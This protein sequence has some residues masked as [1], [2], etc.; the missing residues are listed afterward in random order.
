MQEKI[1][2]VVPI[3]N[4]EK[5]LDR[6][7]QSLLRQTYKNIEIILVDDGSPD[8]CPLLCD[9]YAQ[10]D[11]RVRVIHKKNGGLSDARN[12]GLQ[13]TTGEYVLY[14][15]SDDYIDLD[16]CERF[17]KATEQQ[18][19]DIVVGSA[20]MEKSDG[21]CEKMLHTATPSGIIYNASEFIEKSIRA[22]QWYAPACFNMYRR[23]FLLQNELFF[24]VGIY[25]EDMQML[26]RVFLAAQKIA[27]IDGV[28]YHYVVRE[29]SIM[30]SQKDIKK[31]NNSIQ[32]LREWKEQFDQVYD[33]KV[34]KI[35][36][37]MLLKCY[38]H[39][40]RIY[41]ITTWEIEGINIKFVMKYSLNFR[42]KLKGV[43]FTFFPY[44]FVKVK[45]G[46]NE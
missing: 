4:V 30:T 39:E 16:S 28:F 29:N 44:I 38:L 10:K 22:Y 43:V 36:Y 5:E 2:I 37:G 24:K 26:P 14:I 46:I 19:V 1:S 7:L 27:C 18:K 31:K 11:S 45:R 6:C 40:C 20:I 3:Y 12:V 23:D 41:N 9:E 21:S 17:L 13:A 15:D 33:E 34:K 32:N 25:F 35:L 42:E 8:R